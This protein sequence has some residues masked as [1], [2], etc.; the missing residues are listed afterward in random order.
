[1]Y[2]AWYLQYVIPASILE[3]G[4]II[5]EGDVEK[6]LK[7]IAERGD[8]WMRVF[9][10]E[11]YY[12]ERERKKILEDS[13]PDYKLVKYIVAKLLSTQNAHVTVEES[14]KLSHAESGSHGNG[15]PQSNTYITKE[16]K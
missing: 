3:A 14:E 9:A 5:G 1:M 8:W 12:N 11:L 15:R 2:S 4:R 16:G 13:K 10:L 6:G 7:I